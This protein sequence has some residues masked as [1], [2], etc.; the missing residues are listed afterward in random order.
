M[1]RL[2][3]FFCLGLFAFSGTAN[4]SLI[5]MGCDEVPTAT[6]ITLCVDVSCL[7]STP[8]L[9][10]FG[11]FNGWCANCNLLTDQGA[12]IWCA[13]VTMNDGLQ[14][15][16]FFNQI[17]EENLDQ[18]EDGA[19]T[20][21]SGPFT[22]RIITVG[23]G[24]PTSYTWGWNSCDATCE[25]P[26]ARTD[27]TLCVDL[28]CFSNTA[29]AAIGGTFNGFSP[30]Q[31]L[32]DQGEGI[33][34]ATIGLEAG[35]QEFKF[36]TAQE[37]YEDLGPEDAACTANGNRVINVVEG[38]TASY[39]YG[40]ETCAT[41]SICATTT[42]IELCVD[43]SCFPQVAAAAV[44]GDFNGFSPVEPLFND[45]NGIYCTTVA[46]ESGPQEF[47]FFFAQ[48]QYEDLGPEDAACTANGNRVINVVEGQMASYTYGWERCDDQ[49]IL[50]GANVEFC[51]NVSCVS[52]V[53]NVNIF[54]GFNNWCGTCTP[55]DDQGDGIWC[56]TVF[57]P[58]GNQEYKFLVNGVEEVF[59]AF[60]DICTVTCCGG[61][62]TNRVVNVVDGQNQTVN[63][64][65]E[66]CTYTVPGSVDV[67][68]FDVVSGV[69]A[70]GNSDFEPCEVTG[71]SVT[72]EHTTSNG[73][74]PLDD[75]SFVHTTLCGDGEISFRV[76][77]VS[78]FAY[79]GLTMRESLSPGA[80]QVSVF[81]NQSPLLKW[82]TRYFNNSIVQLNSFYKPNPAWIKLVRQGNWVFGYYSQNGFSWLPVHGVF[83]PMGEC[84]EAGISAFSYV[85]GIPGEATVD[86]INFVEYYSNG[87]FASEVDP[88][89]FPS[90]A[91]MD[92]RW[93]LYPNPATEHISVEWSSEAQP[94][95][96]NVYN[97]YGQIVG[98]Q[99]LDPTSA[100]NTQL[101]IKDLNAGAYWIEML[102]GDQRIKTLPFIKQ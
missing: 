22:N 14:E 83:L 8:G 9:S 19:C 78:S 5:D 32:F 72:L 51:V 48:Q 1:K 3:L 29:A 31:P 55:L 38:V 24:Q 62:F 81:N 61:A 52:D 82:E 46:L 21:T 69:G 65:W 70:S 53:S 33:F 90:I 45:G 41:E 97:Q 77:S 20:I 74:S 15:F 42:D 68:D 89:E 49:C 25:A 36:F 58:P 26:P 54:G 66:E 2:L 11:G 95:Q 91:E 37:Q 40:W 10:V 88:V 102:S 59:P 86:N 60:Q 63:F 96:M 27:I 75:H 28:S 50:P 94:T 30:T 43:L 18:V 84:I 98:R 71:G 99:Q 85:P 12:G 76:A 47:K 44:G 13:T 7:P 73:N 35:P 39:T 101:S 6:D 87:G 100:Q 34:C 16:K 79:V 17:A 56:T 64:D 80:K 92:A 23:E 4:N 67:W 57:L 93:N